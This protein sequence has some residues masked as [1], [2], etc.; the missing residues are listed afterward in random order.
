MNKQLI[1]IILALFFFQ[2]CINKS[3]KRWQIPDAKLPEINLQIQRY[4]KA[5]FE[6][7]TNHLEAALVDLQKAFPQFLDGDLT[8]SANF[9]RLRSFV[10]DPQLRSI[11][12]RTMEVFP[13]LTKTQDA[14]NNSFAHLSYHFPEFKLPQVYTYISGLQFDAPVLAA[15][16]SLVIAIDCYLGPDEP[17]YRGSGIPAYQLQRM[18][19]DHMMVDVINTVY[20][21]Y[22]DQNTPAATILDEMVK[23]GKRY[24]FLEAMMPD[25]PPHLILGYTPEQF[26][27]AMANEGAVW[28]SMVSEQLLYSSEPLLFRKFFGDGPFTKEFSAEAPARLGDFIGWRMVRQYMD[29]NREQSLADLLQ[30]SDA[31][32]LLSASAYKPK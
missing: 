22:F 11:Y 31:Q 21:V 5:L 8:D 28:R 14:L 26:D 13:V 32:A 25:T 29:R 20:A 24:L 12:H 18:T 17:L 4:G 3:G 2:G 10:T 30:S 19:A 27:W 7:D 23:S 15:D 9:N 6:A 16:Q 1:F